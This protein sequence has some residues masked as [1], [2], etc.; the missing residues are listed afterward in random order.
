VID[1]SPKKQSVRT[2]SR[3]TSAAGSEDETGTAAE[4]KNRHEREAPAQ[5]TMEMPP[6]QGEDP[7]MRARF[8]SL[9]NLMVERQLRRRDITNLRVLDAMSR[10]P[11]HRFVPLDYRELAYTDQPL[12]IGHGQTISQPY[13]VALMTQYARPNPDERALDIGTGSG[14]Q[15]AVLGEL[16]K[17]VFSI[18]II[19][20]L[21]ESAARRLQLLGYDNV[22]VRADDGYRGWP[23][24]APFDVIIIAAAAPKIPEPLIAQLAPGGRLVMPLGEFW[25]ELVVVEKR[26]DGSIQ[27]RSVA[28]VAFV[29]M[30][31]EAA[32]AKDPE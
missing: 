12:P 29:P 7:S 6:E 2:S 11:R 24:Y 27:K 19:E 15:A 20:P 28:P 25:Q 21:A 26:Q 4:G 3:P 14:Y 22:Q 10:V 31:G 32:K 30:T 16:C 18:E 13:M 8:A 17:D 1:Q 23:K 5:A 9:R